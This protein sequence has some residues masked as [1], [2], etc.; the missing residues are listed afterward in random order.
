MQIRRWMMVIIGALLTIASAFMSNYLIAKNN[1]AIEDFAAS[2][3]KLERSIDQ[4]WQNTLFLDQKIDTALVMLNLV[5]KNKAA[6][7]ELE[8]FVNDSLEAVGIK[9]EKTSFSTN[10][11]AFSFFKNEVKSYKRRSL[12]RINTLYYDKLEEESDAL[13]V[14]NK[15]TTYANIALLLQLIGLIFVL[16]KDLVRK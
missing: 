14:K 1:A 4:T 12:A 9:P 7:T 2:A 3:K 10:S 13:S 6:T 16:A 8:Y 11:D 15:N 5:D